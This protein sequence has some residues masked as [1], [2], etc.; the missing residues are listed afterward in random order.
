MAPLIQRHRRFLTS[1][2]DPDAVCD[3]NRRRNARTV[4]GTDRARP[5]EGAVPNIP[6]RAADTKERHTHERI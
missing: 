6:T 3:L 4:A 1:A 2:N 5:E